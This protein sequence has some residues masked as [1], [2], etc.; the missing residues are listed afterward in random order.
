MRVE[1]ERKDQE[2]DHDDGKVD[3]SFFSLFSQDCKRV[4]ISIFIIRGMKM[5]FYQSK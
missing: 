3:E 5:N 1:E 4:E 2:E